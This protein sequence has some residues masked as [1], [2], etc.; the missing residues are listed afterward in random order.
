MEHCGTCKHYVHHPVTGPS[1]SKTGKVV[2]FLMMKEC[3]E[4]A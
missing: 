4:P 1:C 3:Y 2:S